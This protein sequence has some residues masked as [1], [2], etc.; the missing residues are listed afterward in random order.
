MHCA[1]CSTLLPQGANACPTCGTVSPAFNA[2]ANSSTA[3]NAAGSA[4]TLGSAG[5]PLPSASS[6]V[7]Q[8]PPT[9]YGSQPYYASEPNPYPGSVTANPYGDSYASSPYHTE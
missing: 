1:N 2:N 4:Q 5:P 3:M 7:P 6:S 9:Y 8:K